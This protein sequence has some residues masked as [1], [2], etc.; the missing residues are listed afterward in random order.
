MIF[1]LRTAN[2]SRFQVRSCHKLDHMPL[3]DSFVYDST[4]YLPLARP[5]TA[6]KKSPSINIRVAKRMIIKLN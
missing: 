4:S 3:N 5:L 2:S 1:M 6:S